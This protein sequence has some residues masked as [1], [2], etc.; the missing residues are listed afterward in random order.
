M[1]INKAVLNDNAQDLL[2]TLKRCGRRCNGNIDD[3]E[4][5]GEIL[6]SMGEITDQTLQEH[7][8]KQGLR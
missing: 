7:R 1:A 2:D 3:I 5:I 8:M 4:M 6:K